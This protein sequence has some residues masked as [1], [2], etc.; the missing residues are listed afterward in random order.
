MPSGLVER[1]GACWAVTSGDALLAP[2]LLHQTALSSCGIPS[3]YAQP[4]RA[5]VRGQPSTIPAIG[6]VQLCPRDGVW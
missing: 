2:G 4:D 6:L 5:S 3:I 1:V